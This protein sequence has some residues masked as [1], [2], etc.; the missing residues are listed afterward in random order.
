MNYQLNKPSDA[1]KK[2]SGWPALK[3]LLPLMVSEKRD[4]VIAFVAI[5]L[6]AGLTLIG[7]M[8]ISYIIDH[9]IQ[10]SNYAGVVRWS[11]LLLAV[12]LVALVA[13][14]TQTMRM[15]TVGRNVLFKLRNEIFRKLQDLPVAFFNQN[16]VGDLIS[17]INNDTDKLNNFFAQF[18][19]RFVANFFLIV[20][21]AVFL[22]VLH[23]NL[24]GAAL[25]P[26]VVAIVLTQVLGGWVKKRNK[27]SLQAV[28]ALSADIQENLSNFKVIIAFNRL[29]YFRESFRTANAKNFEASVRSGV[30]N[31]LFAPLYTLAASLGQL[32]VVVYGLVLIM[33]GELTVGLLI[34]FLLYLNNFY[35][36]LR[37]L[38]QI[39]SSLQ[40]SLAAF[41]RINDVLILPSDLVT[42]PMDSSFELKGTEPV[43][44]FEQ[45]SFHYPDSSNVLTNVSFA[46]ERGKT[47]A[48]VGPTGGGKTTT[49]SLIARLY[50]PTEGVVRLDGRDLRTFTPE[51]RS[52][53]VGFILQEPFLFSG[54]ILDNVFYGHPEHAASSAQERLQVLKSS[55]LEPLLSNFPQGLETNVQTTGESVSLGQR[56][57]IAFVRAVLRQPEILILDE[58]TANIDTVTEQLLEEALKQLP[59]STTKVIIAHRL[60]T[61]E[62]ADEIFFVNAGEVTP[63]GS[64][65]HAVEL[66]MHGKRKG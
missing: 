30:A 50:D 62:N 18:L 22:V 2:G 26:A 1:Q 37:Q 51:E 24:G 38:G 17:R 53:K 31:N 39:W 56:Q 54:S 11:L 3:R 63:A 49:A 4:F 23:P 66:L 55:G 42:L 64:L 8:I 28:G 57:L 16:K 45:V 29:D 9:F 21:A 44:Q 10:T 35:M 48:L 33:R 5:L 59:A 36:P 20:G 60:N 34:G 40:Q 12:Y 46:F 13:S 19:M 52:Q 14:Y 65:D 7:P 47:Y 32:I 58:A 61:I 15:G 41:E 43:I 27:D 25:L 6:N